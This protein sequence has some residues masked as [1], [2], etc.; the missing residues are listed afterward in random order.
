M[1]SSPDQDK[2]ANAK[3][4]KPRL[5][6]VLLGERHSGLMEGIRRTLEPLFDA[7]LMAGD[8]ASMYEGAERLQPSLI[9]ME[10][11]LFAGHG[12]DTIRH[13]RACCPEARIIVLSMHAEA[14]IIQDA[15]EAGAAG[16][17]LKNAIGTDL[18]P[19]VQ[20]VMAGQTCVPPL[21]N[22]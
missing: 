8:A 7:V 2:D 14:T 11:S 9:V 4:R 5:K 1:C 22:L 21:G 3:K 16:Y 13:L 12:L 10:L 17:V 15:L 18:R 6:C 19:C 20:A